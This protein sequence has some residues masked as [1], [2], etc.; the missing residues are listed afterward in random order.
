[1]EKVFYETVFEWDQHNI[2]KNWAKHKVKFTECE[3][4]FMDPYLK[5]LPDEKHSLTENRYLALGKTKEERLLFV[6]FIERK[7][8]IRV[9]SARDASRKE[10][11]AYL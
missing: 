2:D 11:R 10:R 8:G 5:I 3:E 9:I 6:I 4:V 7:G 1:M